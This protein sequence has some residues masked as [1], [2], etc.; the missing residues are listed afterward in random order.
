MRSPD[1]RT[2]VFLK[3][4]LAAACLLGLARLAAAD[5]AV[6]VPTIFVLGDS[7]ARN[8]GNGKNGQPWAGWGTPIADY[9]DPAKAVVANVAHAGT[10]SR[11]YFNN[12][13]DWSKVLPQIKAGDFVLLVFGINDGAAPPAGRG[14]LPGTGDETVDVKRPDGSVETAHTYGW[15]MSTMAT[16]ARDKGAR[17]YLLTVT[18]RNIWT[19]PKVK[20]NDA[21][22]TGPLPADYDSK[23]DRIERGTGNGKYTQWT[24]DVGA[25]LHLPVLDLTNLCA[26]KYEKMGRETVNAFYSDHNHTY[27]PGADFVAASIVSGLKAF[28]GSPFVALLSDKG[29]AVPA[30]DAKYLSENP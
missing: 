26:D 6:N 13:G 10:S 9:F 11:T 17:V 12:P 23:E 8:P 18:T 1:L 5:A 4:L 16:L 25:K 14:S 19:N 20:F 28:K 3:T 30:A 27:V 2:S 22:P 24:K 21:T 29:R 7:T 15:Y